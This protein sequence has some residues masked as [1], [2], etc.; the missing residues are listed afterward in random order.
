MGWASHVVSEMG[1]AMSKQETFQ[2]AISYEVRKALQEIYGIKTVTEKQEDLI[3]NIS[4]RVYVLFGELMTIK[5]L[6]DAITKTL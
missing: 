3:R 6:K 5:E 2:L 1:E 4:A